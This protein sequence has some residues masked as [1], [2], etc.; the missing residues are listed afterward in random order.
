M[1]IRLEEK[2]YQVAAGWPS[3]SGDVAFERLLALLDERIPAATSEEERSKLERFRDGVVG[4]G[5]DVLTGVLTTSAN[6]AAK[7][8]MT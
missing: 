2:G 5:R 1:A 3:A 4:V 6:A 7:G 8:F